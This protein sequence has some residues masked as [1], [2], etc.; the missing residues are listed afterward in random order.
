MDTY[1][2]YR[3]TDGQPVAT[4]SSLQG[5]VAALAALIGRPLEDLH[6]E[7]VDRRPGGWLV[8]AGT[9]PVGAIAIASS[10]SSATTL[11]ATAALEAS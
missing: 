11:S 7:S 3:I 6:T 4:R 9:Q 10:S 5:A 1:N 8:Y 2:V